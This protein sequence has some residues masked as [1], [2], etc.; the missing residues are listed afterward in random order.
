VARF[1]IARDVLPYVGGLGAAAV[2][3]WL[4]VSPWLAAFWLLLLAFIGFFFRDPHRV[5]PAHEGVLLSP[6]DG[7]VVRAGE[8]DDGRGPLSIFLSVF[9]VHVNRAPVSGRVTRIVYTRGRFQA[10]FRRG[11]SSEN[12]RNAI[13]IES[14]VG[15]VTVVQIAGLLA[16]RIVCTLREGDHVRAGDRIGLIKFGSRVD[17]QAPQTVRWDVRVGDRVT[18]GVT[19]IGRVGAARAETPT[20]AR[21]AASRPRAPAGST[22][23]PGARSDAASAESR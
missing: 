4:F 20:G 9:D 14:D 3:S 7:R 17:V 19:V 22:A 6:A 1:G 12:E 16:R 11:A 2:L 10:A 5:P 15:P 13:T 23:G 18:G 21:A 8:D